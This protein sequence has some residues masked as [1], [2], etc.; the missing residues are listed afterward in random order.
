MIESWETRLTA[1]KRYWDDRRGSRGMPARADLD[2]VDVPELLPFIL[3]VETAETLEAFRYRLIGTEACRGFDRDRTGARFSDLPR[4]GNFDEVYGG[5]WRSFR[6]RT[7]QYF[8]GPLALTGDSR[9]QFSRLTLPLSHDGKHV[10]MIL[11]GI[12]YSSA[13]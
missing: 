12:V 13:S 4:T 5:Y 9:V 7:P 10:D 11:G 8:H 1:L 3:L 2:P 6:E